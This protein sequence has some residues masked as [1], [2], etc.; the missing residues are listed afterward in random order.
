MDIHEIFRIW[1]QEAI[2]YTVSRLSRLFHALQ[3]MRGGG[4]CSRN[5]SCSKCICKSYLCIF[6]RVSSLILG[7]LY[8]CPND[9]EITLRIWVKS[10]G[11][12]HLAECKGG[13]DLLK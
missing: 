10:I 5:A 3:T 8:N 13:C 9:S 6:C 12:K 4:V 2:G 7:Q 11:T 1:T